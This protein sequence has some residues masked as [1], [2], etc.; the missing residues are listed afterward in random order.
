MI[1]LGFD[2]IIIDNGL[3]NSTSGFCTGQNDI[4]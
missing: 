3:P 1:G 4:Q 2:G